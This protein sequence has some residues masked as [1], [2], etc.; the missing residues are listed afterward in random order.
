MPR[1]VSKKT[2]ENHDYNDG[3]KHINSGHSFKYQNKIPPL[4]SDIWIHASKQYVKALKTQYWA[5]KNFLIYQKVTYFNS[6]WNLLSSNIL[7]NM[8]VETRK[9]LKA[10]AHK[11]SNIRN[12]P[13]LSMSVLKQLY[14]CMYIY[15][16]WNY[17]AKTGP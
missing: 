15:T 11:S 16:C 8:N 6:T 13:A 4:L 3:S 7:I 5:K 17:M 2:M 12:M 1:K 10:F 9:L 14:I